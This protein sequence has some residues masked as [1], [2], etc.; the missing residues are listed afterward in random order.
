MYTTNIL[1]VQPQSHHHP[2]SLCHQTTRIREALL[3]S[4]ATYLAE[5]AV[6]F[7]YLLQLRLRRR[8]PSS[9]RD[10]G[11]VLPLPHL[12]DLFF[13][14]ANHLNDCQAVEGQKVSDSSRVQIHRF[15]PVASKTA[16]NTFDPLHPRVVRLQTS[17]TEATSLHVASRKP[18]CK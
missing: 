18:S 13:P 4:R 10:P 6:R 16:A 2:R 11:Q 3:L 7:L 15:L 8:S 17:E 12:F 9:T 1:C 5:R 14:A